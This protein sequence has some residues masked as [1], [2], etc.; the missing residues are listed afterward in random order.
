MR[1]MGWEIGD[2]VHDDLRDSLSF[3]NGVSWSEPQR[4][5]SV[6]K[7]DGGYLT[8]IEF[9]SYF[10]VE[11]NLHITIANQNFEPSLEGHDPSGPNQ[12]FIQSGRPLE[13]KFD[14]PL[15][16]DFGH[17][18]LAVSFTVPLLD[19]AG[20]L[21]ITV[22][23]QKVDEDGSWQRRG[24]PMIEEGSKVLRDVWDVALLIGEFASNDA[25]SWRV[26]GAVPFDEE[27]STRGMMEGTIAELSSGRL[28]MVLRGSNAGAPTLAGYK[29]LSFSED[30]GESWSRARPLACDNGEVPQSSSTGSSLFRSRQ[31]GKLY[32]MGNLCTAGE[33]A[34][35]NMPR[36][37][38]ILCEVQEE[39]FALKKDTFFVIDECAAHEEPTVQHS[40]FKFYLDRQSDDLVV[41]LTRYSERGSQGR[42]WMKA[43][44]YQYRVAL[45]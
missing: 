6:E 23:W 11:R 35:G 33:R 24:F 21:L 31:N 38:L 4:A 36:S 41:Y 32:W 29:W 42:D 25:L 10:H 34:E 14:P 9:A 2:D 7:V 28:A 45:S 43:D 15:V 39:P 1:R 17:R 8:Y 5:L 44:Q 40:N 26:A 3:D 37:P 19:S 20:R 30:G 16:S 12:L 18:G 13:G 22:Q 27:C